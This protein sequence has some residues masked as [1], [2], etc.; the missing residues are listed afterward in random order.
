MKKHTL[1][2]MGIIVLF[3]CNSNNSS[4]IKDQDSATVQNNEEIKIEDS[5]FY[6]Y[7]G[8]PSFEVFLSF[9]HDTI[10]PLN[11]HYIKTGSSFGDKFIPKE[12]LKF[13]NE[14]D[15][16]LSP[17]VKFKIH[18]NLIGLI[19]SN[20]SNYYFNI[21]DEQSNIKSHFNLND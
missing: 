2:L 11:D 15:V 18:S 8:E 6:S 21:Y 3:A 5:K 9:F 12:F 20:H 14:D 17:D 13:T 4:S 1:L 16:L 19:Y 10:L 7:E